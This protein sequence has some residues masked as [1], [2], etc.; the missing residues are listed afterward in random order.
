[1]K[2]N[3]RERERERERRGENRKG[4]ES[5]KAIREEYKGIRGEIAEKRMWCKRL[6]W[7]FQWLWT[8]CD[9]WL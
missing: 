3:I 5:A 9:I 4:F 1:M 7:I 2:E 6:I 8:G